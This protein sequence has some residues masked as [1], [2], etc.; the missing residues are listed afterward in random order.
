MHSVEEVQSSSSTI[1]PDK[2]DEDRN[3]VSKDLFTWQEKFLKAADKGAEDLSERV[4]DIT[5]RQ[6][7]SQVRGVGEAF[8]VKL[9]ESVSSETS[10]LKRNINDFVLSLPEEYLEEAYKNAEE[11]V[12]RAVKSAA[13]AIKS[14]A[15]SLRTWKQSFVKETRSLV[16]AASISTLDVLDNIRDLGLQEIGMRWAW[17]D[18]VT[19]KDWAKYHELKKAFDEWRDEVEAVA[20]DHEGL[21]RS[22]DAAEELE[23]RG[24]AIAE[25]AAKELSRL[26][27]VGLWKLYAKDNTDDF[28]TRSTPSRAVLIAKLAEQ[29]AKSLKDVLTEGAEGA[30]STVDAVFSDATE[31]L[32]GAVSSAFSV[33]IGTEPGVVNQASGSISK[34]V[35][36]TPKPLRE[37]VS[38]VA[39]EKAS[40]LSGSLSKTLVDLPSSSADHIISTA[41]SWLSEASEKATAVSEPS[42]ESAT[43][44]AEGHLEDAVQEASNVIL[45][46]QT[47]RSQGIFNEA[48]T[49]MDDASSTV[50]SAASAASSKVFSGA[51]AQNVVGQVP[52]FDEVLADDDDSISD[53]LQGLKNEAGERLAELTKVVSEALA[54]PTITKGTVESVTS[55][56]NKRYYSALSA[57]SSALYG[58]EPGAAEKIS[59]VASDRYSDAVSA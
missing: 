14:N 10:K 43:T 32:A 53:R 18:G 25:D 57:A 21:K 19:Y 7:N 2:E 46:T 35:L 59:R 31:K 40:D 48:S 22:I 4:Q 47:S 9:E 24:L 41:N 36:G 26:K 13:M 42:M 38:S 52:I 54:K 29:S 28:S 55:L 6:V 20:T 1:A 15:Q 39:S 56:A 8:I 34:V 33:I 30:K 11:E 23:S 27:E 50:E 37:Q 12:S 51:M 17:M 16:S 49:M 3:R 5:D 44:I 58:S 45:G